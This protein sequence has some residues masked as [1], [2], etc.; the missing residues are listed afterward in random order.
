[1][2]KIND[3]LLITF[4][5]KFYKLFAYFELFEFICYIF[6]LLRFEFLIVPIKLRSPFGAAPG[7]AI[8]SHLFSD[9]ED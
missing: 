3:K 2:I 6:A 4:Y 8:A 7:C 1:M 9:K 5:T